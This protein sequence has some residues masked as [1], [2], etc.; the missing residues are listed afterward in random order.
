MRP[1]PERPECRLRPTEICA[2]QLFVRR[3]LG[4]F[5]QEKFP[6]YPCST[7][8][9]L[10]LHVAYLDLNSITHDPCGIVWHDPRRRPPD[11][12]NPA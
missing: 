10:P 11:R 3:T 12:R 8:Y 6:G 5:A 2:Q 4:E 9:G 7:N 1:R